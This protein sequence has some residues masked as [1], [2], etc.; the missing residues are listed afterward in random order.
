MPTITLARSHCAAANCPGVHVHEDSG[1]GYVVG[2]VADVP[3][4]GVQV[5]PGEAVVVLP[6]DVT[7][8]AAAARLLPGLSPFVSWPGVLVD[9]ESGIGYVVGRRA[10]TPPAGVAAG[11]G[12]AVVAVSDVLAR[13]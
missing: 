6:A 9:R 12:E 5:G 8:T 7:A 4:R 1:T 13:V 2:V 10:P 11:P 3:P